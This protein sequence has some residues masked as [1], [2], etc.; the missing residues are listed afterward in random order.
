VRK[1]KKPKHQEKYETERN[2]GS[3][4]VRFLSLLSLV[5]SLSISLFL[6]FS[7]DRNRP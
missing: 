7:D 3:D 5:G 4:E 6:F 2:K 1:K